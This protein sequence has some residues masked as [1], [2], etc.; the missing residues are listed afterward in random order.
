M[1]K[2]VFGYHSRHRTMYILAG[3]SLCLQKSWYVA[4]DPVFEGELKP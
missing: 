3:I 4:G 1:G 2:C